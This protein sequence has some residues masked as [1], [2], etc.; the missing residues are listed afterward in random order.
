M[1]VIKIKTIKLVFVAK[2]A[3]LKRKSKGWL[4]RNQNNLSEW[5][6]VSNRGLLFQ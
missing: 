4:A 2:N 5:G 6:D 1:N 3:A